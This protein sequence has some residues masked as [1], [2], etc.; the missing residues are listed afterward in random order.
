MKPLTSVLIK[1]AGP[2][3]NLDCSYCFYLQKS[4][5]FPQVKVHRMGEQVLE[6]TVRQIMT[7]SGS[8]V[9]FGWQGGEPTLM[10]LPFFRKAIEFQS[11]Y[12]KNQIVGNGLQT[13][14]ILLNEEWAD[15]LSETKFLVGLSIDGPEYIH[16]KYRIHLNKKG[17]WQ[18]V[19][20]R[21]KMLLNHQVEVNALTVVNDYSAQFPEEIY[22]F[23][24]SLGLSYMQFIPCIEPDAITKDL[25]A[26]YSVSAEAYGTFL[27]I[28]FDLWMSDF[29]DGLPT[30]SIRYFDSVF[31]NYVGLP[32]PECTLVKECGNYV[33]IEHTGDVYSCDFF[34]EPSW[35][36][37]NLMEGSINEMLNSP[38]QKEFGIWKAELPPECPPCQWLRYCWGGCTKDRISNPQN[39]GHNHFCESFKMFF[40]HADARLSN[41]AREWIQS[42]LKM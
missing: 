30:T 27:C 14:G 25:P 13:N 3:C 24:K 42:Q 9:S 17:S 11:R 8:M 5:I 4:D 1:P 23:H 7:Q 22:H 32:A 15:F 28:L 16:D 21:A 6:E 34:V 31:H 38:R 19:E 37:G 18:E 29:K 36:L 39:M 41:L 20:D 40:A 2:D 26:S 10:G 35:H 12:G 33:V